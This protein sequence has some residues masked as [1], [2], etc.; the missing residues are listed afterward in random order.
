MDTTR[1]LLKHAPRFCLCTSFTAL[2]DPMEVTKTRVQAFGGSAGGGGK[3]GKQENNT[4]AVM[5][6][7]WE[8]EGWTALF[9][10]YAAGYWTKA[11]E[12]GI[13]NFVFFYWHSLFKDIWRARVGVC[14]CRRLLHCYAF[15]LC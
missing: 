15:T 12:V 13:F 5:R 8:P 1:L 3:D 11:L 6:E 2:T 14:A 10:P 9:P 7:I 4:F